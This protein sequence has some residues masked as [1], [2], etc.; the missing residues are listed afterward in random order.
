MSRFRP[1]HRLRQRRDFLRLQRVGRR[2]TSR[3]FVVL[4]GEG[5][6]SGA[7]TG[8]RLGVTVSKKVGNAVERNRVKRRLREWF[9]L[10]REALPREDFVVIARRGA[11]TLSLACIDRELS[12]VVR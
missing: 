5:F 9:R 8:A 6:P 2:A 11:E 7:D 10:R 1:E 12:Q 3:H 4:R